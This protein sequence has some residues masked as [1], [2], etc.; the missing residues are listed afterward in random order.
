MRRPRRH[1]NQQ[2]GKQQYKARDFDFKKALA[3]ASTDTGAMQVTNAKH[4]SSSHQ[5]NGA[6]VGYRV[7]MQTSMDGNTVDDEI[8]RKNFIENALHYQVNLTFVHNKTSEL[9]KA[10]KGE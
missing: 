6:T 3:S 10:I 8:E 9:M 1:V 7:P 4:I 5:V 2:S